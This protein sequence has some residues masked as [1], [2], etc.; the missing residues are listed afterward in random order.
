MEE[1]PSKFSLQFRDLMVNVVKYDRYLGNLSARPDP[2]AISEKYRSILDNINGFILISNY[3]LGGYEYVSNGIY[4]HLG[5]DLSNWS[6]ERMTDFMI[7]I[8][9]ED[10]RHFLINSLFPIVLEYF[11]N[12]STRDTGTDFRYTLCLQ[13]KNVNDVFRWYLVDTVLIEVD[14]NGFP[15]RGL[16][17]CTD[18]H[19]IKRD[20]C[21]YYS[22]TKKNSA[23]IYDVMLEGTADNRLNELNLTPREIELINL[24]SRGNTNKEIAEKL[25]I[26]INTVQTH[27]KNIMK[28]TGCS[29]TADLTNFAFSRGWL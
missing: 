24:I 5:Y 12:H 3:N 28:K 18:I 7:S 20:D 14:A 22:I 17:T 6:A 27:R 8:I 13:L 10:H 15:V 23:G 21:V 4:A 19:Q 25:F 26:S 1:S 16:I 11:K 9:R 29:G 2:V